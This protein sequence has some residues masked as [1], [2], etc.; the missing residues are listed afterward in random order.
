MTAVSDSSPLILY[1]RIGRLGLFQQ[2]F[3]NF[4]LPPAVWHEVVVAGTGLPGANEVS[5]AT[6]IQR[7]PLPTHAIQ[8]MPFGLDPGETEA[9]AL[10]SAFEPPIPIVIDDN[11]ARRVAKNAGLVV[12]GSGG[13]LA[14]A[15]RAGLI[16]TVRPI[17][18]ELRS[19]GLF[20]A[21]ATAREILAASGER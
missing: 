19:E 20:L 4:L 16:S 1:A 13:L 5:Q 18:D 17:L 6:W 11:R 3:G 21:D 8:T 12:I 15:K 7:Q 2:L 10:A 14:L 9:I